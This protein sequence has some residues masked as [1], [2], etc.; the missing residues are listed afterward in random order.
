MNR[1]LCSSGAI[2]GKANN[3]DYTLLKE[4]KDYLNCD[5]YELM[6]YSS[7]YPDLDEVI[8]NI[9]SYNLCIPVFHSQKS[10]G[11]SLCGMTASYTDGE[12]NE[13]I[14]TESE[15][16]EAFEEG[17]KRFLLN[18]KFAKSV[19]AEKMVLHLWNGIVSDKNISKNV[20]R[21]GI[22]KSMADREEIDLLVEN[23]ICNTNN[24]LYNVELVAK[25]YDDASFVY[26]TKMAEFHGQTMDLFNEEHE[27]IV[28]RGKIKHLHIN[29]YGGGY[30]DWSNMRVLPIGDGHV[31]FDTFFRKLGCYGYK[32]DFTV[33]STALSKNGEVNFQMLNRCFEEIDR[34]RN[35]YID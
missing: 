24:P 11:E 29:D 4:Y 30:M 8:E 33:E 26:D 19:G 34:L 20:E 12:Y 23:V 18:L 31:D 17:T 22:W 28:E 32:G 25:S 15:D 16:R 2:I 35:K 14:M 13:H 5:G 1:I 3:S 21:Y 10:L 27:W 9:Q 6:M 7:W